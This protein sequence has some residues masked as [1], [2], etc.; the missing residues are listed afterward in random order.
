MKTQGRD[1]V[2]STTVPQSLFYAKFA[3]ATGNN[4][5]TLKARTFGTNATYFK[6]SAVENNGNLTHILPTAPVGGTLTVSEE[7]GDRTWKFY[8]DAGGADAPEGYATFTYD[9]SAFDDKDVTVVLGVYKGEANSD[10]NKLC[11]YS[12]TLE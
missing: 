10:E 6:L 5:L 11:I 8:N 7:G 3:I 1:Y 4:T 2:V 9:L 12:I